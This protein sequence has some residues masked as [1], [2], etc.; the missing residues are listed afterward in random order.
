MIFIII[1][2]NSLNISLRYNYKILNE[3]IKYLWW[4]KLRL[5]SIN[6][7]KRIIIKTVIEWIEWIIKIRS[8]IE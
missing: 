5:A 7:L 8:W 3:L 1:I 6:A 2:F 4:A